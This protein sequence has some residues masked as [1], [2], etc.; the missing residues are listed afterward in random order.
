MG[1]ATSLPL[2]I[3]AP[4]EITEDPEFDQTT[5]GYWRIRTLTWEHARLPDPL[6]VAGRRRGGDYLWVTTPT[7]KI[8]TELYGLTPEISK[9][10]V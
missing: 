3:G 4:E 10:Y 9:A 2:G 6:Q 5:P 8:L 1:A 7:M